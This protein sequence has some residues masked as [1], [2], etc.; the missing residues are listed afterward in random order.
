MTGL[1]RVELQLVRR[2]WG[3]YFESEE[4]YIDGDPRLQDIERFKSL[5]TEGGPCHKLVRSHDLSIVTAVTFDLQEFCRRSAGAVPDFHQRLTH[6][7]DKTLGCL[8]LALCLARAAA[9]PL[10]DTAAAAPRIAARLSAPPSAATDIGRLRSLLVGKFVTVTGNVVR[11]SSVAPLVT[12]AEFE[13]AR[14]GA[15]QARRFAEGKFAPPVRCVGANCKARTFELLRETAVTVD[16][17][18]LRLQEIEGDSTEPGRVPRTLEEEVQ[19][20]LVDLCIPS[21]VEVQ[22]DLVD[23]CIPADVVEA[24]EDLVDLCIPGDV[25]EVQ[26]DLVDL[27][28]PGDVVT[29]SG[30]VR[31]VNAELA[32]GRFGK[33]AKASGLY[34]LYLR[35]NC[36]T[37][38]RGVGGGA[39][40]GDDKTIQQFTQEDLDEIRAVASVHP[41]PFELIVASLCPG[42]FGHELVK[43]GLVLALAGDIGDEVPTRSDAHVL[44]V[45][46]PGLG[47]SQM[48]QAVSA[49]APRSVYVCGN[50][51][52]RVT[53]ATG[54]TVTLTKDGGDVGLE[55]GALVLADQGVCCA[56]ALVLAD[57][58]VCCIDE[59]D[60]MG[61]DPTALLEAMEQ[62]RISIA[63]GGIVASL[64][65]RCSVVAAANPAGGHYSR[66]RTVAENLKM[67]AALLSRFDLV[68]ILVDSPD[69]GHD[70]RLSEHIMRLHKIGAGGGGGSGSQGGASQQQTPAGPRDALPPHQRS[71]VQQTPADP[72]DALP[73]LRAGADADATL[74]QRL[75]RVVQAC[76]GDVLPQPLLRKYI[77]YARR[78]CAPRLSKA[79]ARE[80]QKLYLVMRAEAAGGRLRHASALQKLYL[81]MRA[82]AAGGRSTPITTRQLESMVRLSQARAKA[83][84]REE[85]SVQDALDVIHMMQ[86]SLLEAHMND[87]GAVD[88]VRGRGASLP[89]QIKAFVAALNV[90]SDRKGSALFQEK[91]L[92]EIAQQ[93]LNPPVADFG[94]FLEVLR[95]EC[96]L[97]KRGAK[98]YQLQTSSFSQASA[99]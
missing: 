96:Y 22:E 89:K 9:H 3:E 42:I 14:C 63:K 65:A 20:D 99:R 38:A 87:A 53:A 82:E 74:S 59:F 40:D 37:N 51:A 70:K 95:S 72:R 55:S 54:L 24:Q 17:Q 88:F 57:Q 84:L 93:R 86:E 81:V 56:G 91:E 90:A 78:Y 26:E 60:K 66:G 83:D 46:D 4:V 11:A 7:P 97:L 71:S 15:V 36:V 28:I 47:K 34:L 61:C 32:S 68:F 13:C 77:A 39:R 27:C 1:D 50:T 2:L 45:G 98:V 25:V 44:V 6:A 43:A 62:Q 12:R 73:P 5:L 49:A 69:D 29:V 31:S 18:R 52:R 76:G 41:S 19:E 85:V 58:G 92:R 21:E 35:A 23:L 48:L 67:G 75:R 33:N 10:L 8:G 80:L 16:Y 64:S 79:A 94:G 30:T